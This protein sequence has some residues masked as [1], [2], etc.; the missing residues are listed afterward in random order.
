MAKKFRVKII[1]M[2]KE[3]Y[4]GDVISLKTVNA[5]GEIQF[6]ANHAPMITN[7]VPGRTEVLDG[8]GEKVMLFTSEGILTYKDN[9][10]LF[11]TGAAERVEDIDITRAEKAAER[12][13]KRIE[14]SGDF[15]I[16]RAQLAL[17]RA[18]ERIKIKSME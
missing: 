13:K 16:K 7:S 8:D 9:T 12:A 15:D 11:M 4:V 1:T 14:K 3:V 18:N 5:E 17:A 2:D 10:L 6:L